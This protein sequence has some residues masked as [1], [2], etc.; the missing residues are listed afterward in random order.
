MTTDPI[1]DML[2]RIRNA[3]LALHDSVSVPASRLKYELAQILKREGYLERVEKKSVG[4]H[5]MIEMK[6]RRV[7]DQYAIVDLQRMSSPS[8]RRYVGAS[9]IPFVRNGLGCAILSTSRGLMTDREARAKGVGGELICT[10]W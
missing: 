9:E 8:H 7:S 1:A 10:I 2:T 4:S 5:E 3:R 6:L